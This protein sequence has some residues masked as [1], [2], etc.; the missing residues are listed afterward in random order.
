MSN[1]S[2]CAAFVASICILVSAPA[3]S[4][5]KEGLEFTGGTSGTTTPNPAGGGGQGGGGQGGEGGGAGALPACDAQA[6]DCKDA[7]PAGWERLGF[8]PDRATPC[9]SGFMEVDL[10]VDPVLGADTCACAECQVTNPPSCAAGSVSTFY[11]DG[12][13][14]C[15]KSGLVLTNS[16]PGG[17]NKF[18]PEGYAGMLHAH[19]LFP[20][21]PPEGGECSLTASPDAGQVKW[22]EG[23]LCIPESDA[24]EFELC[25]GTPGYSECVRTDGDVDCP[26]AYS[27]KLAAGDASG[28]ACGA[29][30][31]SVDA[32]CEGTLEV[33]TDTNCTTGKLAITVDGTCVPVSS[34]ETYARYKYLGAVASA[35]CAPEAPAASTFTPAQTICCK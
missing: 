12:D 13:A 29:C 35:T 3:C 6:T 30:G 21:P 9:P 24:C 23:R 5:N 33:Y 8:A 19:Q 11:D 14:T 17:C 34:V 10:T 26:A 28:L 25:A 32:V 27:T 16:P 31:C 1:S 18:T 20:P 4:L 2:S 7:V 22:T 15:S